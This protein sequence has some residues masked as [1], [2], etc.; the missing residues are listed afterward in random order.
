MKEYVLRP[1]T[2]AMGPQREKS[3]FTYLNFYGQKVDIPYIIWYL[4]G[5]DKHIL[6]DSGCSSRDYVEVIKGGWRK[7]L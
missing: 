4:E 1:F 6:I 2:N 5:A 7:D 3:R